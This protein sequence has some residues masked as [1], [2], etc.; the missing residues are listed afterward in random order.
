MKPNKSE[1]EKL[2]RRIREARERFALSNSQLAS[3]AKVD[4][5]QTSRILDGRF[6]TVSGNV[7]QICNVLGVDPCADDGKKPTRKQSETRAAWAKLEASVRR[8][9]DKTPQ[10]A[11]RL[12]RVIDAVA[13][14]RGR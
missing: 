7:L 14:I 13:Q 6:R 10:G 2:A 5:G 11:E 9:W 8:A 1:R 3:L 4:P 12:V